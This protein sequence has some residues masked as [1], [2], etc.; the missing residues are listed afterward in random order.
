MFFLIWPHLQ[1][2][3]A[4]S[5]HIAKSLRDNDFANYFEYETKL[6]IFFEIK[7]SFCSW[8]L[9]YK[10]YQQCDEKKGH[11]NFSD[12]LI[13]WR[14]KGT[15]WRLL[16]CMYLGIGLQM[17]IPTMWR[18]K[19]IF[20]QQTQQ[21]GFNLTPSGKCTDLPLLPVLPSA[22]LSQHTVRIKVRKVVWYRFHLRTCCLL[23]TF[24]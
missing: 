4:K 7:P 1:K 13:K 2:K 11:Y 18:K 15:L 22:C 17:I 6:K 8:F 20:M 12:F 14:T 3:C 23:T 21:L 10:L 19:G 24:S 5:L 9:G 16:T